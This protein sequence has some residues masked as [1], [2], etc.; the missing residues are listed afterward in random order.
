[1]AGH[2]SE[3]RRDWDSG[4]PPIRSVSNGANITHTAQKIDH[5]QFSRYKALELVSI[6]VFNL[7]GGNGLLV[8]AL[9]WSG[10]PT[11]FDDGPEK[12][13]PL[14][15]SGV[16]CERDDSSRV[17]HH[18]TDGV[19]ESMKWRDSG[20]VARAYCI[21]LGRRRRYAEKEVTMALLMSRALCLART[22]PCWLSCGAELQATAQ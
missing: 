19:I 20:S 2:S 3:R 10:A 8:R 11:I 4:Q 5:G 12:K 6:F 13:K 18:G 17:S 1:M 15:P 14:L 16:P 9:W 7:V 22:A 21:R